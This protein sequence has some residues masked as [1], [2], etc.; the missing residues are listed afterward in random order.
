MDFV[1]WEA[2]VDRVVLVVSTEFVFWGV[3]EVT[4]TCISSACDH[5]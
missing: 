3:S 2:S 1:V 4:G 5:I